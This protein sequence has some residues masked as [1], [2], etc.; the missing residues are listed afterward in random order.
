VL[1]FGLT[2]IRLF[3]KKLSMVKGNFDSV[4]IP[5]CLLSLLALTLLIMAITDIWWMLA[6]GYLFTLCVFYGFPVGPLFGC[7]SELS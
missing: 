4:D 1:S 3:R 2:G 7:H 6:F 5:L